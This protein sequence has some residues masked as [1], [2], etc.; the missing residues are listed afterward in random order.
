MIPSNIV[1][2]DEFPL[3]RNGKIDKN[4][5]PE[6]Q[7]NGM[8]ADQ[9]VAPRNE[10]EEKLA[11]IWM[12]VLEID[13]IGIG[14]DFFALGGDSLLSIRLISSIRRELDIELPISTFFELI[15]IEKVAGYIKIN[16]QDSALAFEDYEE[17]KL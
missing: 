4:A 13:K 3:T 16:R 11:A 7:E 15:T 9:F 8:P 17:I 1:L 5:L 14:D 2:L 10:L 12:Q 6:V